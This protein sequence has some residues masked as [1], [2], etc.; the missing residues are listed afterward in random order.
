MR[1]TF[2]ALIC[3]LLAACDTR[4]QVVIDHDGFP[5]LAVDTGVVADTDEET[6]PQ[7]PSLPLVL[8]PDDVRL[9]CQRVHHDQRDG[10]AE[11]KVRVKL[12]LPDPAYFPNGFVTMDAAFDVLLP[13][14]ED[15][16]SNPCWSG[17]HWRSEEDFIG[18]VPG[19]WPSGY[20]PRPYDSPCDVEI[21]AEPYA[22][23]RV[24]TSS[25]QWVTYAVSD[26]SPPQAPSCGI[27]PRLD[28]GH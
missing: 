15:G 10:P 27:P 9:L 28:T 19:A 7:L 17:P 13:N 22:E 23:V 14:G 3:A 12:P 24:L 26:A 2:T 18:N 11:W 8:N 25:Y 6:G 16:I 5:D 4:G 21:D 20:L 1:L